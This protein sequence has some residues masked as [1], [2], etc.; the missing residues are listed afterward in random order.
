MSTQDC[1]F[2]LARLCFPPHDLTPGVFMRHQV[3][4][5]LQRRTDLDLDQTYSANRP[6]SK[7]LYDRASR[8]FPSGVTH[9]S[10][11]LKPFPIYAEKAEGVKK[12][13]VDG[14][15]YIDYSMGHGSLILGHK[16]PAVVEALRR[17]IERGTHYGACH[18]L[19][20]E[21]G[22]QITTLVPSAEK[23]RFVASG[24]EATLMAIRLARSFKGKNN[25]I[26]FAGHYH[27]WHDSMSIGISP[28]FDVPNSSGIPVDVLK[29]TIVL[30]PDDL[31]QIEDTLSRDPDVAGVILEPS[32]GSSGTFPLTGE[33]LKVLRELTHR[34]GVLLIFDEVIT[35]FRYAR[36]G[37]QD[38]HGVIP[39]LTCLAK[40]MAG[41]L[42]GG[43]V[44]GK[45]EIMEYLELK[46]DDRWNRHK[47]ILHFGTFNANPISAA[48]G[49]A[50]LKI[51]AHEE[52]IPRANENAAR[53]RDTLNRVIDRHQINWCAHGEHSIMHLVMNH[54]C[55]KERAC[56]RI[57]CTYDYRLLY[58]RDRALLGNF[59]KAM[60]IGGV[61]I[62]G[63]HGWISWLHT[64]EIAEKT[65]E[66]F[67]Q[68]VALLKEN[69][70]EYF[71][72]I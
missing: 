7:K 46:A 19:E 6:T 47:K 58:Q 54:R 40:I 55:P 24:T 30:P 32:G 50:T 68:A 51:L 16:H 25:I 26:R 11:F 8:V 29:H 39:D 57:H 33:S 72:N 56:D 18:E 28:P 59:R 61:D 71:E 34:F 43:A 22:E 49:T 53:I 15:E 5:P 67:D 66:A 41:G 9:D 17:Q 69:L 27:G 52:V 48:A 12:W 3:V 36:G 62:P 38:L 4:T 65:G 37:A 20:V 10:R 35:G 63:D 64:E 23:V 21:W 44:V 45:K 70:P 42:P 31:Q 13:D 2:V 14:L 1:V 60:L